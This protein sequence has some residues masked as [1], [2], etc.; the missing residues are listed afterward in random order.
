MGYRPEF[1]PAHPIPDDWSIRASGGIITTLGDIEK[2]ERTLEKNYVLSA[3]ATEAMFT[4]RI[5]LPASERK[6]AY[7]WI[8]ERTPGGRHVAYTHGDYWGYQSAYIRYLDDRLTLFVATNVSVDR[9]PQGWR[10][11][12]RNSFEQAFHLEPGP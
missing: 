12:V 5:P 11:L 6:Q 10:P 4:T 7:S 1:R 8:I 9:G 3:G 2:W